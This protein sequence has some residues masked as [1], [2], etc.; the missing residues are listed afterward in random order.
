MAI[1]Q[2]NKDTEIVVRN[3]THGGFFYQSRNGEMVIDLDEYGDEDR[4][5]FGE[6]TKNASRLRKV[7]KNLSLVIVEV[8]GEDDIKIKD[9]VERLKIKDSYDELLSLADEK[10]EDV[11][12]IDADIIREFVQDSE[13]SSIH[14]ILANKK[15]CLHYAIAE[16]V[17][18]LYRTNEVSDLNKMKH[19]SELLGY[20]TSSHFWNDIKKEN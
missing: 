3:N 1:K 5:T 11:D 6:L 4:V 13:S 12:Y 17:T 7:L 9:V 20:K 19:V 8:I 15:S 2:I 16:M 18:E 10:L 14:K